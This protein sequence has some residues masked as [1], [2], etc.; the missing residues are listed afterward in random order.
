MADLED[1]DYYRARADATRAMALAAG[2]NASRSA[3]LELAKRYT[4]LYETARRNAGVLAGA[5]NETLGKVTQGNSSNTQRS[6]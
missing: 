5:A 3:H 6:D 4:L 2:D 1:M